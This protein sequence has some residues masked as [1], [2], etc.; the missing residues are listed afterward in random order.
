VIVRR[1]TSLQRA[2][3]NGMLARI[4]KTYT[5]TSAEASLVVERRNSSQS[6]H[7]E[8]EC[9]G[10]SSIELVGTIIPSV[11]LAIHDG[12]YA[13]EEPLQHIE[14]DAWV[15]ILDKDALVRLRGGVSNDES[16]RESR[17]QLGHTGVGV[18]RCAMIRQVD[19][20]DGA[21]CQIELR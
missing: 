7:Y 6:L 5:N 21:K 10:G 20:V 8:T 13:L 18:A 11:K 9:Y 15:Q 14:V 17:W 3:R 16:R 1:T 4:I 12:T 2:H 19:R